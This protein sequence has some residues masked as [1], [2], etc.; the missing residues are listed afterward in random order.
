MNQLT[1]LKYIFIL[2]LNKNVCKTS[3]TNYYTSYIHYVLNSKIKK[4]ID[5]TDKAEN[6]SFISLSQVH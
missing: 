5:L 6:F 2:I 3:K 1:T 4:N